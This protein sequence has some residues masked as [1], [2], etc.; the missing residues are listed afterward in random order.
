MSKVKET[1]S[2]DSKARSRDV[3][4]STV[5]TMYAKRKKRENLR[6]LT[7]LGHESS[8]LE[9]IWDPLEVPRENITVI[10]GRKESYELIKSQNFGVNLIGSPT[11]FLEYLNRLE[12]GTK[13]DV[14]NYD[15]TST[16]G[17]EQREILRYIAAGGFLGEKGILAT[18][19]LGKREQGYTKEWF[20]EQFELYGDTAE[21]D[22]AN[23]SGRS[24]LISRMICA[25][26][27][28]GKS[29]YG[30]HPLLERDSKLLEEYEK[31]V[32]PLKEEHGVPDGSMVWDNAECP[33]ILRNLIAEIISRDSPKISQ[34]SLNTLTNMV[35]Y[36]GID[37][38]SSILQRR[39]KYV[40]DN[41]SPMLV[42]INFFKQLDTSNIFY[43]EFDS[44]SNGFS[45]KKNDTLTKKRSNRTLDDC[46][47]AKKRCQ[48]VMLSEREYL[49][50]SAKPVLTKQK[51][52]EEFI[53]GRTVED[54]KQKYRSTGDKP[55]AQWKAHV[56][57][58]TYKSEGEKQDL[59]IIEHPEDGDLEKITKE[60]AIDFIESG[61]PLKEIHNAYPTS[62]SIGQLR[63]YKAHITMG[64]YEESPA[65][66]TATVD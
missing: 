58:G 1:Y 18:T 37:S 29:T 57:M 22:T 3:I 7:L 44:S 38:Y 47:T 30:I 45:F 36:Q 43:L 6:V 5:Q 39:L 24:D 20:R 13:F 16:F 23:L 42:D 14:I 2:Y 27:I 11:S 33:S 62:F 54:I 17:L 25:I 31:R 35:Y 56:T 64:T 60:D 49:G 55:L 51:A 65:Q 9:Q 63:S 59:E 50:S 40:G 61:I 8:E 12:L 21:N 19:F 10:E 4:R 66:K 48:S 46:L 28:D 32:Q 15:S 52:I 41:G 34:N 53:Q 26:F